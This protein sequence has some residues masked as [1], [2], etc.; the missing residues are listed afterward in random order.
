MTSVL[1]RILLLR[2]YNDI[3]D[4]TI[5]Y[6]RQCDIEGFQ[7]DVSIT[8]YICYVNGITFAKNR[9]PEIENRRC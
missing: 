7:C 2:Q 3:C 5:C 4:F 9:L 1:L 6:S 8:T